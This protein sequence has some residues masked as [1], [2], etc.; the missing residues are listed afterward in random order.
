MKSRK[1][2]T[3]N[4][5]NFKNVKY[6]KKQNFPYEKQRKIGAG[7]YG[8]VHKV[9]NKK[10]SGIYAMKTMAKKDLDDMIKIGN[11][12]H[13]MNVSQRTEHPNLMQVF[14]VLEDNE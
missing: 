8:D 4:F 12:F 13:E 2:I 9:K 3:A 1:T 6:Y 11:L 10:T 14:E 5:K 7:A